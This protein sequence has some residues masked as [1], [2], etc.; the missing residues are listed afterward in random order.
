[1]KGVQPAKLAT[2]SDLLAGSQGM[3]CTLGTFTAQ[4]MVTGISSAGHG[5]RGYTV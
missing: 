1:M 3:Y 2:L 4:T 5:W